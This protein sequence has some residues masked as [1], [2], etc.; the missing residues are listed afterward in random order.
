M[1]GR[2]AF[3][4]EEKIKFILEIDEG[5]NQVNASKSYRIMQSPL[6]T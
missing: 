4:L 2:Q 6:A 3:T 5:Q 1:A